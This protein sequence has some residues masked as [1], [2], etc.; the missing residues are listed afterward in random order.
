MKVVLNMIFVI[1][2]QLYRQTIAAGMNIQDV[3]RV[4][5]IAKSNLRSVEYRYQKLNRQ[6][7]YLAASNQRAANAFQDFSNQISDMKRTILREP[8]SGIFYTS[9]A[10]VIQYFSRTVIFLDS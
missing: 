5:K 8:N 3:V 1:F 9:S 6:A 4:I 10:S 2:V 7:N